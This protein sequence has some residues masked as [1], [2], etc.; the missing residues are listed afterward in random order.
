MIDL[1]TY[2]TYLPSQDNVDCCTASAALLSLEIM[3]SVRGK[4]AYYSRLFTYYMT[5]QLQNRLGQKGAD[6]L[7]TMESLKN[8]VCSNDK[9]PFRFD[10]TNIHPNA[11]AMQDAALR[12]VL[13]YEQVSPENFNNYLDRSIPV[14]VGMFTGR[15][16]WKLKGQLSEQGYIPINNTDNRISKGHAVP[17]VGY[18]GDGW[19]IANSKGPKWGQ[20]GLGL[21]PYECAR[22]MGESFIISNF[23]DFPGGNFFH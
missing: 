18:N 8:G 2:I 6:L 22:D 1:S 5:R 7:T 13:S 23:T 9:W 12:R 11:I 19:I 20:K 21:L 14:I 10:R 15:K 4:T 16:F 17:I 3:M